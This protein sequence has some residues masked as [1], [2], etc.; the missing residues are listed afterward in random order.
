MNDMLLQPFSSEEVKRVLDQMYPYKSPGLDVLISKCDNPGSINDFRPISLCNVKYKLAS[1]AIANRIKL[2]INVI[3]SVSQSAF[4][5][6]RLISDNVLMAYKLNHYLAHK[7]WGSVASHFG[8]IKPKRGLRQG[9]PLSPYLLLF[10]AEAFSNM[11]SLEERK[12]NIQGTAVCH[13]APR[14]SHIL[15]ADDTLLFCQATI[16]AMECVKEVLFR[17]ER[18]SGLKINMQ[19]SA[20]VFNKNTDPQVR[21]ILAGRIGVEVVNKHE[22]YLGLPTVGGRSKRE[23]F[24]SLKNRAWS[25]MQGWGA[26]RLS[27]AGRMVLIKVVAQ[28]IPTYIMGCFLIPDSLL[29]AL[30]SM[31][32][33]FFGSMRISR[34]YTG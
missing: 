28:A 3:I 29:H 16:E 34:V 26:K 9:D 12:G 13:R 32:A 4:V 7:R 33:E 30:E 23:M 18:A 6:G 1:K 19:K 24:V 14:F 15:F 20:I 21:G 8:F 10:C 2:L 11:V 27:Q 25:K 5:P 31:S 17:F 22:K